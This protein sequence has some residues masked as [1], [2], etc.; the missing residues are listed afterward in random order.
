MFLAI[1]IQLCCLVFDTSCPPIGKIS[2]LNRNEFACLVYGKVMNKPVFLEL[3]VI[4]TL[5]EKVSLG[6]SRE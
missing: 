1:E 3:T 5:F 4:V 2:W 6:R